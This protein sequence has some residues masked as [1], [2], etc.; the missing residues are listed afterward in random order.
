[1]ENARTESTDAVL[2]ETTKTV[3]RHARG[4]SDLQTVCGLTHHVNPDQLRTTS[5]KRAT[6]DFDASK[7][8][9]CFDD[10]GGY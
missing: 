5:V 9:R 8:G 7:C 2:N 4:N 10:G 1:M 6:T 3:H